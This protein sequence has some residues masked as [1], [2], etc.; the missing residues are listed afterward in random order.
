MTEIRLHH[1]DLPYLLSTAFEDFDMDRVYHWLSKE[2]YWSKGIPRDTLRRAFKNSISFGLFHEQDGQVGTARMVTDGATF[3]YLA[4][5]FI[6]EKYRGQGLAPW[7][8]EAI[9]THPNIKGLRRT[10][11]ATSDMHNLYRK[12]GFK[13]VRESK[14]LMEI[15]KPDIYKGAAS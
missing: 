15:V 13:D 11:L 10:M 5:V 6:D 4:D 7:M 8:M 9:M 1:P 3:G 2:A 14:I 12:F